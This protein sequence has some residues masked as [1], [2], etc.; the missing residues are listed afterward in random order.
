MLVGV[1]VGGTKIL[2]AAVSPHELGG[3]EPPVPLRTHE[4]PTPA[5]TDELDEAL[6]AVVVEAA[7]GEPLAAVGIGVPGFIDVRGI[8]RQA[9]NCPAVIGADLA[10]IVRRRFGVPCMVDN[11]ANCAGRAAARWD[12]PDAR[13]VVAVTLGTGI[14]GGVVVDR[15]VMRGAHGFATEPGHMIV[16]RDG[17]LC[18]CGQRG[19]W[20]V[21]ASGNG[22]GRL[23]RIAVGE[24]RA[25]ALLD[26]AGGSLDL[27]DGH[28]VARLASAG[29]A[30]SAEIF[31]D[32]AGW[33][34][35]GIVNLVNL[36]DPEVVVLGGGVVREG[37]ALT[38][39]VQAALDQ[40]P[41]ITKGRRTRVV[42]SGMEH[43]AGAL[44]AV[45]LAEAA[46]GWGVV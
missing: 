10:S 21:L 14:G 1:D 19:C 35:V 11:D 37:R 6:A 4:V 5:A 15:H 25:P 44:G 42:A 32:F 46:A 8:A 3:S 29:D 2:A 39:R 31:D 43:M 45:L 38:D 23:G 41:T 22:L 26:A 24:G 28:L 12:A 18:P 40:Y 20:E 30:A 27:I 17:E 7:G 34:A 16:D 13:V 9:P 36:V 33:I